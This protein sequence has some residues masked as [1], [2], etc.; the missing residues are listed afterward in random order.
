MAAKAHKLVVGYDL[1]WMNSENPS[2]GIYQY[3]ETLVTNILKEPGVEV[4]AII[5]STGEGILNHLES[6]K[7]F[8]LDRVSGKRSFSAI[9]HERKFDVVHSPVQFY[10]HLLASVPMVH[11]LHDLQHFHYPEFFTPDEITFRNRAYKNSAEFS[12]RVIVSYSHVKK[13][14]VG[15]YKI[16]GD[17][18]DVCNIGLPLLKA[19]D[20][21]KYSEIRKRYSL[22]DKYLFYAGNTWRHKNHVG[23]IRALSIL[24][25]RHR[26][27]VQLVCTGKMYDD[28]F[29]EIH[30]IVDELGLADRVKF[31]GYI[32]DEDLRL[33]LSNASLVVIP[34]LYEAGSFPLME[35]MVSGVP[36]ICSN[37]TS[38]SDTIA[39]K[40]FTF[41]PSDDSQIAALMLQMLT[42][43]SLRRENIE[44]SRKRKSTPDFTGNYAGFIESYRRA[45]SD[46]IAKKRSDA[47]RGHIH[48]FEKR[49]DEEITSQSGTISEIEA[50]RI[51]RLNVINELTRERLNINALLEETEKN[52]NY[53]RDA[54][55]KMVRDRDRWQKLYDET[56]TNR[57]YYRDAYEKIV[58]DR[59]RWHKL[60][61][62]TLT[63][64]EYYRDVYE[65]IVQDRDRW[66]K[67]YDET[68]ISLDSYRQ[69]N[70][71][72]L[73]KLTEQEAEISKLMNHPVY[74]FKRIIKKYLNK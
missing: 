63:N 56:V 21:S 40:R 51:A 10:H 24:E 38:L 39:D 47:F 74:Y 3:A 52:R 15:H 8:R 62:E 64:R 44:N 35:A 5:G 50:D 12:E 67:L 25:T 72:N 6:R 14:I 49:V 37:V 41:N 66:N 70:E 9:V 29:P 53:Y 20:P 36:V 4:V 65:K 2:G 13:D 11:T 27:A 42:D 54:Y 43:E 48:L 32:P 1:T 34:T 55:E 30:K 33:I 59:D 31:T 28:Y 73:T 23:L 22:Q 57:G 18:I 61:D 46:F 69:L 58:Q 7:N 19:V 68:L 16:P 45:L 60:Y 71:T 26:I 17:K